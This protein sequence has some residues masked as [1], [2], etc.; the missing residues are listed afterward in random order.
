M[1]QNP[2]QSVS[3]FHKTKKTEGRQASTALYIEFLGRQVRTRSVCQKWKTSANKIWDRENEKKIYSKGILRY[4]VREVGTAGEEHCSRQPCL[5]KYQNDASTHWE[6]RFE[7]Q[8][9]LCCCCSSTHRSWHTDTHKHTKP[10]NKPTQ[11]ETLREKLNMLNFVNFKKGCE[12]CVG[13]KSWMQHFQR[14]AHFFFFWVQCKWWGMVWLWT[15]KMFANKVVISLISLFS[16][17]HCLSALPC[18]LA[19]SHWT[20]PLFYLSFRFRIWILALTH[21]LPHLTFR[22]WQSRTDVFCIASLCQN[23]C[24]SFQQIK[25]TLNQHLFLQRW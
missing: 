21:P 20:I 24:P 8:P 12:I 6:R 10:K 19:V 2:F 15:H 22:L 14:K 25:S 18:I 1:A 7:W 4:W 9:G 23:S 11:K 16:P 13:D 3:Q 5:F 17:T